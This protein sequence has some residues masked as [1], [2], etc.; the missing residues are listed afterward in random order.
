M[1]PNFPAS[2]S[3]FTRRAFLKS[4]ALA[5]I[6]TLGAPALLRGQN[7]NSKLNIATI[8][9]A[10]KGAS[11]TDFC[12]TENIVALCDADENHCAQQIRKYPQAKFYHDFRKMF[13]AMGKS[14][15]AVI[16]ATPDHFH[17]YAA[18]T[19]MQLGKHVYCQKPLT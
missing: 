2:N 7:L 16:V 14:V 12:A 18:L 19:A 4:T 11:D 15:D 3:G 13:D 1:N 5:G 9:A 10:G 6:A 17:A 8:G